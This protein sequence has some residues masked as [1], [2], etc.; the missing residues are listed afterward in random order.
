MKDRD[1]LVLVRANSES[2][3]LEQAVECLNKILSVV[4]NSQVFCAAHELVRRHK[5][6]SKPKSILKAVES[7]ELKPFHFLINRN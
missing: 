2:E 7:E 5:I 6:T 4:E 1:L 3:S